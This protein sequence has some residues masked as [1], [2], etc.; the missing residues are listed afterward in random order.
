MAEEDENLFEEEQPEGGGGGFNAAVLIRVA[1]LVGTVAV[2][3]VGGYAIGGLFGGSA[4]ADA[5]QAA[6]PEA[7]PASVPPTSADIANEDF[8]YVDFERITANLDDARLARYIAA[9]ITLAIRKDKDRAAALARIEKKKREM[10]NWLH[11]YLSGLTL[12]TVRGPKNLNRIRRDVE[13][14]FNQ[15]LWPD[16]RPLIDHVLFKEFAVQ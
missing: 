1:I 10:R 9:T 16:S 8:E 15:L 11:V 13:E 3:S 6:Q 2:G 5:N 12:E 4:P 7:A 14:A